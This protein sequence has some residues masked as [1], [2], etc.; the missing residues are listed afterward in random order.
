[1][2]LRFSFPSFNDYNTLTFSF[3]NEKI[4][5]KPVVF[6]SPK[7]ERFSYHF[8][9]PRYVAQKQLVNQCKGS[10][11][12]QIDTFRIDG[13]NLLF[14][15]DSNRNDRYTVQGSVI[16]DSVLEFY[17]SLRSR[18]FQNEGNNQTGDLRDNLEELAYLYRIQQDSRDDEWMRTEQDLEAG[19]K[20]LLEEL[21]K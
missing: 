3:G 9:F 17:L 5:N 2:N 1:L 4:L 12:E 14:L 20:L 19:Y 15:S 6:G 7:L 10:V 16:L 11:R 18:S 21:T 8:K 13:G